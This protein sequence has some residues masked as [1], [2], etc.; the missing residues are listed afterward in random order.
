M[1]VVDG[2]SYKALRLPDGTPYG[3]VTFHTHEGEDGFGRRRDEGESRF[4]DTPDGL[5]HIAQCLNEAADKLEAM[6]ELREGTT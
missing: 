3:E 4:F 5:R 2:M 1:R 6:D